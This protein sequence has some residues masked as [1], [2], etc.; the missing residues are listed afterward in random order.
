MAK[1]DVE[2]ILSAKNDVGPGVDSARKS[3]EKF[4]VDIERKLGKD[5]VG[6]AIRFGAAVQGLQGGFQLLSAGISAFNGDT[7][8]AKTLLESLP[9]G[10]GGVV[11]A[12][13]TLGDSFDAG[14]RRASEFAS[15]LE[16]LRNLT[17]GEQSRVS[18]LGRS[19]LSADLAK[20]DEQQRTQ[21]AALQREA[22]KKFTEELKSLGLDEARALSEERQRRIE[23]IRQGFDVERELAREAASKRDEDRAAAFDRE[24]AAVRKQI[25]ERRKIEMQAEMDRQRRMTSITGSLLAG[26]FGAAADFGNVL[27]GEQPGIQSDIEAVEQAIRR[28]RSQGGGAAQLPGG[29]NQ[30]FTTGLVESARESSVRVA[31][32]TA[33]NTENTVKKLDE[34]KKILID[35][36]KPPAVPGINVDIL[37]GIG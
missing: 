22:A 32:E 28:A 24:A 29:A 17:T 27:A 37:E 23:I 2:I 18:L 16:D 35:A 1:N 15:A 4:G 20:I 30:R 31:N 21:I 3:F 19:G 33:K 6:S 12:F 14:K 9:L 8:A 5:L 11:R 25:E 13:N 36:N 10:I 34:I 26:R 7:E